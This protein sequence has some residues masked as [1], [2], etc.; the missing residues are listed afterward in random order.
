MTVS[1]WGSYGDHRSLA[2]AY[3]VDRCLVYCACLQSR[4][5]SNH[6]YRRHDR[7]IYWERPAHWTYNVDMVLMRLSLCRDAT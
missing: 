3:C 2:A 5:E 4:Q 1:L 7:S 6:C